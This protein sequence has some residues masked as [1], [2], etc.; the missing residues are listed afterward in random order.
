MFANISSAFLSHLFPLSLYPLSRFRS[1][2]ILSLHFH[3]LSLPPFSLPLFCSSYVS[4]FCFIERSTPLP[5]CSALFKNVSLFTYLRV[6]PKQPTPLSKPKLDGKARNFFAWK[7]QK[8]MWAPTSPG[9]DVSD[10]RARAWG[11]L[12]LEENFCH[13]STLSF[14]CGMPLVRQS[15][16]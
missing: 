5:N 4:H 6:L 14:G 13:P 11:F 12:F 9:R 8:L 3:K 16:S 10:S 2:A 7:I 1:P 15:F